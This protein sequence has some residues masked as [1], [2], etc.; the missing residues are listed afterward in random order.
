MLAPKLN[1]LL[2]VEELHFVKQGT[3]NSGE[4][5]AHVVNIVK[6][7]KFPCAKAEEKAIRDTIFLGTVQRP[8][9]K[10]SI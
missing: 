2:A 4:L 8:G 3:M 6:R 5:H 9:T 10:P 1:L 7:C